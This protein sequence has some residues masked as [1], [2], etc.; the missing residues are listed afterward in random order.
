LTRAYHPATV[1]TKRFGASF[2]PAFP[3]DWICAFLHAGQRAEGGRLGSRG[4]ME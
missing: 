4:R 2:V 3:G 1:A